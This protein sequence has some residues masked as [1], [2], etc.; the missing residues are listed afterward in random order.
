VISGQWSVV[1]DQWS[2]VSSSLITHYSLLFTHHFSLRTVLDQSEAE[3]NDLRFATFYIRVRHPN[4][5]TTW[6]AAAWRRFGLELGCRGL[7]LTLDETACD[8]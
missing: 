1:S 2:V 3:N 8:P 5:A 4:G 6:S 7:W